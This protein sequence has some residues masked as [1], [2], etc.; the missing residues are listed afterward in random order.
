MP[1]CSRQV[2]RV[3]ARTLAGASG[4]A[5]ARNPIQDC[6]FNEGGVLYRTHQK[7][8]QRE[9]FMKSTIL[10]ATILLGATCFLVA[11]K[12]S[13]LATEIYDDFSHGA[14]G[15]SPLNNDPYWNVV[16]TSPGVYVYRA[17]LANLANESYSLK[18][19]AVLTTSWRIE[20]DIQFQSYY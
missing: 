4:G 6:N 10:R 12:T 13:L 20:L 3:Q 7:P 19:N 11:I 14:A 16:Q 8:N 1:L 2:A 15:W 17:D 9:T 5:P 18:T